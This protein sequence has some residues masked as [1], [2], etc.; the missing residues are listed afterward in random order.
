MGDVL[1]M[2]GA[3][4]IYACIHGVLVY[5]KETDNGLPM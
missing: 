1:T 2:F 3:M 5:R 4:F